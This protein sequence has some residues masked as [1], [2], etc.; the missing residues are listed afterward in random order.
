MCLHRGERA[1]RGKRV[2]YFEG[3]LVEAREAV[4]LVEHG[5]VVG[6]VRGEL[7]LRCGARS[8]ARLAARLVKVRVV[9]R[10]VVLCSVLREAARSA[11]V[12]AVRGVGGRERSELEEFS[13]GRAVL[14]RGGRERGLYDVAD[15]AFLLLA[16][17]EQERAEGG[18]GKYVLRRGLDALVELNHQ[19]LH[20]VPE[21]TE[22][23]FA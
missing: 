22:C 19:S 16:G 9:R 15:A 1:A 8:V 2:G 21:A 20:L 14:P 3:V 12:C 5:L 11:W 6:D 13:D 7:D 23:G 18:A 4:V 17:P 10:R